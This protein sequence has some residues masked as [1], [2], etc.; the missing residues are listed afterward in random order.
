LHVFQ[1]PEVEAIGVVHPQLEAAIDGTSHPRVHR[2]ESFL[3]WVDQQQ[4]EVLPASPIGKAI[5]NRRNQRVALGR[6]L[7]EGRLR[8]DNNRSERE[9]RRE[10]VGRMNWLF[11]L[12]P[13]WPQTR[14]LELTPKLWRETAT[15][16]RSAAARRQQAPRCLVRT[17]VAPRTA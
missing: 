2:V 15:A 6:F 16:P 7:G 13:D 12:V 8:L 4:L 14:L 3:G 1:G 17:V 11:V 10:A 5:T 9:L